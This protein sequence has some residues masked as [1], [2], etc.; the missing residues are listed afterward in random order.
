MSEPSYFQAF[1]ELSKSDVTMQD[2]ADLE[3]E[4]YGTAEHAP[5]DRA[6]AILL[7]AFAETAL[8][9]YLRSHIGQ[10][11][12]ADEQ[13]SLSGYDGPLAGF[14]AKI[15]RGYSFGLFGDV[16]KND[17]EIIRVV[18]NGFAHCRKNLKFTTRETAEM[19]A[20]LQWPDRG[21][22]ELPMGSG[23]DG[24][25]WGIAGDTE[26]PSARYRISV[27]TIAAKM[28]KAREMQQTAI[29]FAGTAAT[30]VSIP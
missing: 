22:A 7:G 26:G 29:P 19:C 17:L 28:F 1:R 11:L 23:P 8:E 24:E 14:K 30:S 12:D 18:R 5:S 9:R 2:L 6:V 25:A 10:D 13:R 20:H 16:T 21:D 27:H 3:Q 4:L 15:E